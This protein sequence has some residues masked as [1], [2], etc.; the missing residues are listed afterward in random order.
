MTG[1]VSISFRGLSPSE[2][3]AAAKSAG[4][5][6]VEWGGDVHVPAGDVFA[7]EGVKKLTE[8]SGILA[9]SYGSYYRIG[10]TPAEEFANVLAAATALGTDIIRTWGF[11]KS[12]AL[13]SEEEYRAVVADARR[14]CDMAKE[15]TICLE[16]HDHTLTDD[17]HSA[18][19]FIHDVD[20]ENFATYW[21]PNQYRDF[22]YN[23]EAC[24]ALAPLT[25]SVH[26]F[27][28]E[29]MEH[30]PLATHTE[31]WLRY[32][33]IL[34]KDAPDAPLMLEFMHDGRVESLPETAA[35]LFDWLKRA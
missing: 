13:V 6:S 18:L 23:I 33:E 27:S 14:I 31:R 34:K 3:L 35:C 12:S 1:L 2:L 25:R 8:E 10:A 20:R 32:L 24:R 28:W 21:Q 11:N 17:Y 5:D 29:G 30:F 22:A 26:V 19:K 15:K 7:A 9:Y 4:L 16:C